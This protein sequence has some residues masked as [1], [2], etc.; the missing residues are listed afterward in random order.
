[1]T[2]RGIGPRT[3]GLALGPLAF[4]LTA[5][6]APPAGMAPG[7]WLVAGLVVWMAA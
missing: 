3:I 4:A 5:L 1:M 2:E 7:A 6:L